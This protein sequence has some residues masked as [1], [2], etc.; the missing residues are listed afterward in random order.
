MAC[1]NCGEGACPR[2][3]AK[4]PQNPDTMLLQKSPEFRFCG[5]CATERGQAPSPQGFVG[6]LK[7][8]AHRE[9]SAALALL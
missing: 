4:R 9:D 3:G 8:G 1:N 5:R 6:N 2:W 7:Q